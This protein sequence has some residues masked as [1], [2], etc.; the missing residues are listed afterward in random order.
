MIS[1]PGASL[2]C[3]RSVSLLGLHLRGLTCPF[4]PRASARLP[5]QSTR[6]LH[7][8]KGHE[9][10]ANLDNCI[11][12]NLIYVTSS[13]GL[14]QMAKTPAGEVAALLRS[15]KR[16]EEAQGRPAESAAICGKEQRRLTTNYCFKLKKT[17]RFCPVFLMVYFFLEGKAVGRCRFVHSQ[18]STL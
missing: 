13:C 1:V 10:P 3:G 7:S 9:K 12:F 11:S 2:A 6:W 4:L 5:L 15:L 8:S 14:E 17:G 18:C 16:S